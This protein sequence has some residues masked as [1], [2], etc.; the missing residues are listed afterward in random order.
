MTESGTEGLHRWRA[1]VDALERAFLQAVLAGAEDDAERVVRE[2]IDAGVPES[3][4]DDDVIA[5]ALRAV[6]ELWERGSIT[7]ADEHLASHI[8]VRVVAL[9][10]EAFRAARRRGGERVLL[11]APQG[12][13]H[14]IGLQMK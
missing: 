6:G 5:P 10:R 8:A 12:E 14:V 13:H 4:I 2:A 9:Q 3:V 7:V 1:V 11:L